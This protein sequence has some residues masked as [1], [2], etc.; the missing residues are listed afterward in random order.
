[1]TI[2][3]TADNDR[4][5]DKVMPCNIDHS[6]VQ[7]TQGPGFHSSNVV[8]PSNSITGSQPTVQE[9]PGHHRFKASAQTPAGRK[10]TE[11][12]NNNYSTETPHICELD[13]GELGIHSGMRYSLFCLVLCWICVA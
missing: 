1:M 12:S 5:H 3:R 7:G 13:C 9:N 8:Q 6:F 11:V 4:S 10:M 2:Y